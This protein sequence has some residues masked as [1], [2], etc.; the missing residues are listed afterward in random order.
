[1]SISTMSDA[2][3][4]GA[5]DGE[6][7]FTIEGSE[8]WRSTPDNLEER[9]KAEKPTHRRHNPAEN[10]PVSVRQECPPTPAMN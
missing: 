5:L 7:L 1:M 6:E 10:V 9:E 4:K 8:N 2:L 3:C